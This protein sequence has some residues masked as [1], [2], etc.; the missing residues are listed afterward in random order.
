MRGA[1]L[2]RRYRPQGLNALWTEIVGEKLAKHSWPVRI[3]RGTLI[4]A[5]ESQAVSQE[6]SLF[7]RDRILQRIQ[8]HF[9]RK[10]IRALRCMIK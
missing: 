4:I 2:T 9:P 10:R 1:R 8:G 7:F 5:T 6:I 3:E